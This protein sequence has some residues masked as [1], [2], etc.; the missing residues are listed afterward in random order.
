MDRHALK[1]IRHI[2]KR[3]ALYLIII[4]GTLAVMGNWYRNHL[5]KVTQDGN[6]TF[7][8]LASQLNHRDGVL[9]LSWRN[10]W[11]IFP[12]L[13]RCGFQHV[14]PSHNLGPMQYLWCYRR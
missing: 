3:Y 12:P 5:D 6:R 1:W 7:P 2:Q 4:T 8:S 14:A 11:N 9:T 13:F 10:I